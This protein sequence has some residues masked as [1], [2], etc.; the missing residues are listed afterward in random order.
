MNT[1]R[2]PPE[3]AGPAENVTRIAAGLIWIA[4]AGFNAV[5]T[6]RMAE[7]FTWL[8]SSPIAPIAWFFRDVVSPRPVLWTTLLVA[9]EGAMG[10]L[11]L[12]RG[13]WARAGLATGALFSAFLFTTA[14]PY[15]VVMGAWAA[16]L[17]SLS[18][19]CYPTSAVE[20]LRHAIANRQRAARHSSV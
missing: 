2:R 7:P 20:A 8:E 15:T 12:A 13:R 18:R 6:A 1:R 19:K 16:V 9:G 5:V 11:T 4:G 17:S 3:V 10:I 14:S